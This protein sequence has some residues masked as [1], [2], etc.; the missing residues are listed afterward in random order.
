MAERRASGA[1]LATASDVT[2]SIVRSS[3]LLGV[4]LA[5][6]SRSTTDYPFNLRPLSGRDCPLCPD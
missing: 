3:H 1:A 5:P 6:H 4:K 2:P